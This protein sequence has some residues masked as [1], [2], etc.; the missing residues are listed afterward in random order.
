VGRENGFCA[1]NRHF[2]T[3]ASSW[4]EKD[5]A[6][7]AAVPGLV[8]VVNVDQYND[9][10]EMDGAREEEG[11]KGGRKREKGKTAHYERTR[12]F[13]GKS[14]KRERKIYQYHAFIADVHQ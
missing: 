4:K 3:I 8:V 12:P 1:F 10:K 11:G 14:T 5:A 9:G 7:P 2:M 13:R 6:P